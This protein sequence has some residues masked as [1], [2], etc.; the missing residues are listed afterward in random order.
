MFPAQSVGLY[1]TALVPNVGMGWTDTLWLDGL[2]DRLTNNRA[3]R[4]TV[5]AFTVQKMW[6]LL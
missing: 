2:T 6:I 5:G 4:K 3:A 1:S